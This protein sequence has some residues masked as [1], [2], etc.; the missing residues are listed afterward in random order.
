MFVLS[1]KKKKTFHIFFN[2]WTENQ[3]Q[4]KSVNLDF[5]SYKL[6]NLQIVI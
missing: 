5:V 6:S 3:F 2:Q 1:K 4:M